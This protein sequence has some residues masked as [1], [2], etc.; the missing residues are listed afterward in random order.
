[1]TDGRESELDWM[2]PLLTECLILVAILKSV[3]IPLAIPIIQFNWNPWQLKNVLLKNVVLKIASSI[4]ILLNACALGITINS[5]SGQKFG[6]RQIG[7]MMFSLIA[8]DSLILGFL[9][10]T[11][12]WCL[13]ACQLCKKDSK[14]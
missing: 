6:T 13:C 3:I 4:Y 1:M 14:K 10:I 5:Y 11:L 8:A 7:G 2:D 9:L 12:F